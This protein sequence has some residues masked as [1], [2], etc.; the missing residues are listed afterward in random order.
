MSDLAKV[1][2]VGV[3]IGVVASI[4]RDRLT[5]DAETG[6]LANAPD[7]EDYTLQ[8]IDSAEGFFVDG[9]DMNREAFLKALRVGEGT[10]GDNGYLRLVGGGLASSY[11][12]HPALAGW[13]G[14]RMPLAMAQR[15]G[16]PNGAVSTAAGAYQIN[17]PTWTRVAPKLGITDFSPA[18][19]DEVA[20]YLIGEKGA[21]ADV[22]AGRIEQA[23]SKV[24]KVWASL[25]N[26]GYGQREVQFVTFQR[27]YEQAGGVMA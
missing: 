8:A 18:S 16:Y 25:P 24:R 23:V 12:I 11:D 9:D 22:L 15:A 19:Q 2:A 3:C 4:F 10:T 13:G 1:L 6:E 21:Q 27:A 17:R 26:A 14:W 5:A 7:L 20:W